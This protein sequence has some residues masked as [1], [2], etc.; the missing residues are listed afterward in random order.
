MAITEFKLL[1]GA[2]GNLPVCSGDP[3]TLNYFC[4]LSDETTPLQLTLTYSST[5]NGVTVTRSAPNTIRLDGP[6]NDFSDE[7]VLTVGNQQQT[8]ILITAS[9][10]G[11]HMKE[12]LSAVVSVC[13]EADVLSHLKISDAVLLPGFVLQNDA[14]KPAAG[15]AIRQIIRKAQFK[16]QHQ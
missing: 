5:N 16:K 1:N 8:T 9:I 15:N 12:D 14:R 10:T 6:L 3:L 4:G 7:I 2:N 11:S 13:K